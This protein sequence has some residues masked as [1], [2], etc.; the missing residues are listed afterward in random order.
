MIYHYLVSY[1]TTGAGLGFG[2]AGLGRHAPI[3]DF[4]AVTDIG[5][6][7]TQSPDRPVIVL[8]F[9]L[10]RTEVAPVAATTKET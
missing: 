10:L 5:R 1:V 3:D 8:G 6:Q 4:E 7:L 2:N 9:Q